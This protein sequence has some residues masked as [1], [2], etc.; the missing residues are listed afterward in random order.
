MDE[1]TTRRRRR[2][3]GEGSIYRDRT[4]RWHAAIVVTDP[5]TG[6]RVRRVVSAQTQAAV[7]D[8]LRTLRREVEEGR[9]RAGQARTLDAYVTSWLP[10]L[11]TRVRAS[12]WR[13]HE[14]HLRGHI[15]P[16]LGR[17]PLPELTPT[18]VE[19][20]TAAMIARGLSATTARGA[21]TTLRLV[22]RDA[23]RDGLLLRNVAALARPPR[24]ER[25]ELHVL[26]ASQTAALLAGTADDALGPLFTV[27]ATTG[28]RQG[29]LLGL[30]WG[31]IDLDGPSPTLTVRRAL[32]RVPGGWALAETKTV[33]SRRTLELGPTT[34]RALRRQRTRQKEAR[35][36]AGE[37][38]QAGEPELVFTDPLG[39]PLP[40]WVVTK[41]FSAALASLGLPHVRFHDLR[42]G[43]ASLLLAAGVPLKLVSD[44]LGH[45]T[46]TITA[47][48]YAHL[49][50]EQRRQTA[51]AI[52]RAIGE[53]R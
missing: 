23:V 30:G 20:L 43:A 52:E 47:D 45:S 24:L 6:L 11:R 1:A 8:R 13:G 37:L 17:T 25:H 14:Q 26:S 40:G 15:L 49:D 32:A 29:E 33:R 10:A 31:D 9:V 7:R 22:L 12:T 2:S 19:R 42:H 46:I 36:A 44:A 16:A 38:W 18:A 3:R 51:E 35:L 48:T 53:G 28:L 41:A 4:G 34:V 39:R 21:R 5:D 27:A 50:R